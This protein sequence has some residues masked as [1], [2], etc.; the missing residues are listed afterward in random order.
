MATMK[1][2]NF[3]GK[4]RTVIWRKKRKKRPAVKVR[5]S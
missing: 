2:F 1:S 4:R 3:G 5:L